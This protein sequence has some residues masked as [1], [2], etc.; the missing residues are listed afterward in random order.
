MEC[1]IGIIGCGLSELGSFLYQ[2]GF[3]FITNIDISLVA[4]EYMAQ[5]HAKLEE[6]DYIVQDVT[7]AE[8]V[9]D[10]ESF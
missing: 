4:I 3:K 10:E 7:A 8:I 6:M 5:K 1:E 9:T 2:Q